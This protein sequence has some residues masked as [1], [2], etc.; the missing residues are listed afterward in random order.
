MSLYTGFSWG[1]GRALLLPC[2]F[3]PCWC[4]LYHLQIWKNVSFEFWRKKGQQNQFL[5]DCIPSFHPLTVYIKQ[6]LGYRDPLVS[7][8]ET[9]INRT[10]IN[11][12]RFEILE[13]YDERPD[14]EIKHFN[15][16]IAF[17]Y[18]M[19]CGSCTYT[20]SYISEYFCHPNWMKHS[21][22]LC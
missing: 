22:E 2:P 15:L 8:L 12:A 11:A 16:K 6:D 1:T 17:P 20:N 3:P 21:N 4:P 10:I 14:L 18:F 13:H 9:I 5:P 19:R 7:Y